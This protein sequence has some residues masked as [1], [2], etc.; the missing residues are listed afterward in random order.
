M[1][2]QDG[3]TI[4]FR[5]PVLYGD[6]L[7]VFIASQ[8]CSRVTNQNRQTWAWT[9]EKIPAMTSKEP[10]HF[11]LTLEVR[12]TDSKVDGLHFPERVLSVFPRAFIRGMLRSL[13]KARINMKDRSV[14]FTWVDGGQADKFEPI[15]KDQV[16]R[17]LGA[18]FYHSET[19]GAYSCLYN[20][21][22]KNSSEPAWAKFTF[23]TN[24]DQLYAS[25]GCLGNVGWN[26]TA[27]SQGSGMGVNVFFTQPR[28]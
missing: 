6:D 9:F 24:S 27:N 17:L 23:G 5:K 10:G 11:D 12:L 8:P 3:L 28:P 4:H 20:Y 1:D 14:A 21:H 18:P 26:L 2:D 7:F 19:N 15:V 22:L 16:V 13:G 25:E